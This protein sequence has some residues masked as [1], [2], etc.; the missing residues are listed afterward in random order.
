MIRAASTMARTSLRVSSY[1]A[2][3]QQTAMP[4]ALVISLATNPMR[5]T[6]VIRSGRLNPSPLDR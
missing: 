1:G 5:S 4:P 3:G 6:L 2:I